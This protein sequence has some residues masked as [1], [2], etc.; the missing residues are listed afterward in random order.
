MVGRARARR[1]RGARGTLALAAV[2][3][4]GLTLLAVPAGALAWT[5]SLS[6]GKLTVVDAAGADDAI[7]LVDE[8]ASLRVENDDGPGLEGA[9]PAP[10]TAATGDLLCP[11]AT[12][13]AVEIHGGAGADT[14]EN[15]SGVASFTAFGEAGDDTL[16]G[17]AGSDVLDGGEGNDRLTGGLGNDRLSGG[18]GDDDLSGGAGA[19]VLNGGDGRNL[20]DGGAGTDSLTGGAG[21]DTLFGGAGNDRLDA[22]A[23]DDVLDGGPG[24][25]IV[26]GDDGNDLLQSSQGTDLLLGDAGDDRLIV[27]GSDSVTLDG[28]DGDDTLQGGDGSDE[29]DG[30]AGNDRLDGGAGAD[31]LEGGPG[32]DLA[33]YSQRVTPVFVTVGAGLDDGGAG[34]HDTVGGDVEQVLGGAGNDVLTA[35]AGA[36]QLHGGLGDDTLRGGAG[37]DLLDGGAGDDRLLGRSTPPGRDTLRCGGGT[38]AFDADRSDTVGGDCESGHVDGVAIDSPGQ[39]RTPPAVSLAGPTQLIV[40]VDGRGRFALAVHCRS[41]TAGRCDVR[42]TV[43]ATLG[44]RTLRIAAAHV[45]IASAATRRL[46]LRVPPRALRALRR[47]DRTGFTGRVDLAVTDALGRATRQRPALHALL[48]QRRAKA[49]GGRR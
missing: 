1:R 27:S 18:A 37:A 9:A 3:A 36:A 31:L 7:A 48:P 19:D 2:V 38:D 17:G 8:G 26:H 4:A 41:Q 25:D 12:V 21:G 35:G 39:L 34:E 30:G 44:H 23:G 43:R 13:A 46:R 32:D 11:A 42:L 49:R 10:C 45:R 47:T 6:A 14:I 33:D 28:N 40:H 24:D 29:L 15:D 22:A 16:I 20:L 5:A